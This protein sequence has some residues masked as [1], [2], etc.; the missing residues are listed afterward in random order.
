VHEEPEE[1]QHQCLAGL[2]GALQIPRIPANAH[3]D[4][5]VITDAF[6][7]TVIEGIGDDREVHVRVG[8]D[9]RDLE[10]AAQPREAG[11]EEKG[12]AAWARC[13]APSWPP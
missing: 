7:V 3:M 2:G 1:T 9:A 13:R 10:R 8:G 4:L 5:S 12:P 11:A 6:V